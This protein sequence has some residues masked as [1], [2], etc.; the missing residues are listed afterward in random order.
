MRATPLVTQFN[1]RVDLGTRAKLLQLGEYYGIAE[2]EVL[3]MLITRDHRTLQ[4]P[5]PAEEETP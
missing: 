1:F 3:R 5:A 2:S 4:L